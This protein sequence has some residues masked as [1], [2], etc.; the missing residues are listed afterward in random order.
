MEATDIKIASIQQAVFYY[1]QYGRINLL[2]INEKTGGVKLMPIT[3][4]HCCTNQCCN[5]LSYQ[6]ILVEYTAFSMAG[7]MQIEAIC[8]SEKF[9]HMYQTCS[10]TVQNNC[11]NAVDQWS[12][13][14]T[15][16]DCPKKWHC[17]RGIPWF[18]Q[19]F[20]CQGWSHNSKS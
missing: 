2:I 6:A 19:E 5:Q 8:C 10:V 4:D 16:K 3:E 13:I 14:N 20:C 12:S 9:A 17:C 1:I 18:M 15:C 11:L 7:W